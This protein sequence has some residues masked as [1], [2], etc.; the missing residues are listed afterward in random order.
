[1]S[2]GNYRDGEFLRDRKGGAYV[3]LSSDRSK[4]YAVIAKCGHCGEGYYVPIMF[5]TKSN[6]VSKA[7]EDIKLTPRVKGE[8]SDCV[9]DAFE[10]SDLEWFIINSINDRDG[11]LRG[12]II[13]DSQEMHDRRV[14]SS[15]KCDESEPVKTADQYPYYDVLARCFAPRYIGTD[16]V[17][18][19]KVNKKELLQELFKCAA[20]RYG[21]EC[22]D[23]FFLLLYYLQYGKSNDMGIEFNGKNLVYSFE[24]I[25]K[26][27]IVSEQIKKFYYRY[28]VK[29][30]GESKEEYYSGKPNNKPSRISRFEAR[31]EKYRKHSGD[32]ESE[33]NGR[34]EPGK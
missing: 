32:G 13:K 30:D 26:S 29:D 1:M 3:D 33:E 27:L 17:F 7:I 31:M 19:R 22:D 24:G 16:L 2:N 14:V 21:I 4:C 28:G 5:T 18:P 15:V 23:P 8:R 34:G 6:S 9:L 25:K 12:Y 10:V 11:Y 20:I